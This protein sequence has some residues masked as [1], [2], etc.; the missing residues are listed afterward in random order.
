MK[1]GKSI[2]ALSFIFFAIVMTIVVFSNN[3]G[4][5]VAL[6]FGGMMT[7]ICGFAYGFE[8]MEKQKSKLK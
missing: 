6:T 4:L 2:I 8:K 7:T 3:K 1:N 5:N